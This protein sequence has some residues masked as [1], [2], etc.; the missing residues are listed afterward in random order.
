M[1]RRLLAA[2]LAGE[3]GLGVQMK[4]LVINADDFGLTPGVN[5]GIVEAM[6]RGVVTSTSCLVYDKPPVIPPEIRGRVGLHL[7]YDEGPVPDRPAAF[8]RQLNLFIEGGG[9]PTHIDTHHHIHR[10]PRVFFEV[11]WIAV[12]S[13]RC[14]VIPMDADQAREIRT[15]GLRCPDMMDTHWNPTKAL[16]DYDTV[17]L[18]THPGY[19]DADLRAVSTM[20]GVRERELALLMSAAFR[21]SLADDGIQLITMEEL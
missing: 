16:E 13:P 12:A 19:N 18:M 20:T 2:D 21:Q 8:F 7:H 9:Y 6:T 10:D 11:L 1:D 3:R 4:R 17:H 14:A 5:R 15:A